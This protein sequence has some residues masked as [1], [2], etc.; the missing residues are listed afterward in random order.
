M[1]GRRNMARNT[2]IICADYLWDDSVG[3][4][5]HALRLWE[6]FFVGVTLHCL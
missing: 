5:D 4:Y 1:A 2:T 6:R 3:M